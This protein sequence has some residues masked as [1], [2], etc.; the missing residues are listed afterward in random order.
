MNHDVPNW[1]GLLEQQL[2]RE[3]YEE[4]GLKVEDP[5]YLCTVT[6]L[7]PDSVPVACIKF[8]LKYRSGKVKIPLDF[9]NWAWVNEKEVK[10][11]KLIKGI[12]KE[13]AQ[14]IRIYNS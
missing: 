6:F 7:R 11:Y 9:E 8:A 5:R 10:N 12:D 1:E 2:S 3:A 4:S 13:I 14:T